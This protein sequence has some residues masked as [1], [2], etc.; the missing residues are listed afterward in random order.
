M[1][2]CTWVCLMLCNW[3]YQWKGWFKSAKP[4]SLNTYIF[5]QKVTPHIHTKRWSLQS[6]KMTLWFKGVLLLL[7]ISATSSTFTEKGVEGPTTFPKF[8]DQ[9]LRWLQKTTNNELFLLITFLIAVQFWI[10]FYLWNSF[11]LLY[12]NLWPICTLQ[13]FASFADHWSSA[14]RFNYVKVIQ[15]VIWTVEIRKIPVSRLEIGLLLRKLQAKYSIHRSH[16][17]VKLYSLEWV[18]LDCNVASHQVAH[19]LLHD[20]QISKAVVSVQLCLL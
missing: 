4:M 10:H 3:D 7:N 9:P 17:Y 16:W 11:S 18:S 20:N 6:W 1:A 13:H 19:Q 15:S 2:H 5:Q 12:S 8:W 14:L